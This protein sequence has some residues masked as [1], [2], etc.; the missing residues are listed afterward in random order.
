[1]LPKLTAE[2]AKALNNQVG[3]GGVILSGPDNHGMSSLNAHKLVM[4]STRDGMS[5]AFASKNKAPSS[6]ATGLLAGLLRRV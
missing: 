2:Q 4:G 6:K 5:L 1:M 3:N